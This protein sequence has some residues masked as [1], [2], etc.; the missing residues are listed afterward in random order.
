M[1]TQITLIVSK[2][3]DPAAV[4][5]PSEPS[6]P[7]QPSE[8]VVSTVSVTISVTPPAGLEGASYTADLVAGGDTVRSVTLSAEQTSVDVTVQGSGT[9]TYELYYNGALI[10]STTV[11][12]GANG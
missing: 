3:P 11:N 1:K 9:I 10:G 2:G 5:E 12:F 6:E 8:P 4:T 7:T